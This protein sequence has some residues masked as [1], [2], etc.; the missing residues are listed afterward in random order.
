MP[1]PSPVGRRPKRKLGRSWTIQLQADIDREIT[2]LAEATELPKAEV[3]RRIFA[4]CVLSLD[5]AQLL[6]IVRDHGGSED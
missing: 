4:G 1:N 3:V 6:E 5:Y 2:A